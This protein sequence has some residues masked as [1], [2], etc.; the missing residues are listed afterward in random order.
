[1][2]HDG[3][4]IITSGS[5]ING[6]AHHTLHHLYFNYNYG[7]YFTIWDKIGGSHRLPGEEQFNK[8]LRKD[9]VI[10]EK[11]SKETNLDN[12]DLDQKR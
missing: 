8:K 12:E 11:Q 9:E 3:E 10:W 2:I 6:A 5:F 7:Q 4:Y 1:M